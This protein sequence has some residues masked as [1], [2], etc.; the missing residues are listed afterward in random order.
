MKWLQAETGAGR[1]FPVIIG[2]IAAGIRQLLG[3][4]GLT[5]SD[6][7]SIG[8]GVPGYADD[9]T[10]RAIN[11]TNLGWLDEP[12]RNEMQCY[13]DCPVHVDPVIRFLGD[14]GGAVCAACSPVGRRIGKTA[15][16][17]MRRMLLLS[18][19]QLGRVKLKEPLRAELLSHLVPYAKLYLPGIEKAAAWPDPAAAPYRRDPGRC[20]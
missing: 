6:I 2:D 15:L 17:A 13:F 5:E 3:E 16:E 12:F 18:D 14:K 9:R 20:W 4:L 11:C 1:P 8:A 7:A 19:D 10:G